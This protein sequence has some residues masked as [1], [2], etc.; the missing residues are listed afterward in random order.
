MDFYIYFYILMSF[1]I[2]GIFCILMKGPINSTN[3]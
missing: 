3:I 2:I 1:L